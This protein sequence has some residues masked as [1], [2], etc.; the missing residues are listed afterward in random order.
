MEM[1]LKRRDF[2]YVK[3]VVNANILASNSFKIGNGEVINIGSGKK[4]IH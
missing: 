2:T 1:V 4:Y 3:D